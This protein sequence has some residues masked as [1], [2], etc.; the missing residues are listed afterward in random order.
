M[1]ARVISPS[2]SPSQ[3]MPIRPWN[4]AFTASP[5]AH[6][7]MSAKCAKSRTSMP[8]TRRA[9]S[10][11]ADGTITRRTPRERAASTAGSTP[12]TGWI[13]PSNASSP[14]RTASSKDTGDTRPVA[15][16]MDAAIDRS[17]ADPD[18][19]IPAGDRFTVMRWS[20]TSRPHDSNA[21]R[22]RSR[23]SRTE[24]SSRPTRVNATRPAPAYVST[25]TRCPSIPTILMEYVRASP[26]PLIAHPATT[27]PAP[28]E[29][30]DPRPRP[31]TL[32]TIPASARPP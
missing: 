9:S 2:R 5:P 22:T 18:F 30:E 32:A 15:K 13:L 28:P 21:A 10:A 4:G 6:A 8:L 29:C 14:T 25:S 27:Q 11:H 12:R 16:A 7:I 31:W 19:G 26:G 1:S 3:R 17:K 20:S 24:V 23:A